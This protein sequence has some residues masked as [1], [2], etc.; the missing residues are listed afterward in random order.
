[1]SEKQRQSKLVYRE[2]GGVHF[3]VR[4]FSDLT[5][6][7]LVYATRNVNDIEL[8]LPQLQAAEGEH[9]PTQAELS[10]LMELAPRLTVDQAYRRARD[11]YLQIPPNPRAGAAGS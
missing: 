11:G 1:M 2:R 6:N 8:M 10:R 4:E 9:Q 7:E 5:P 3:I